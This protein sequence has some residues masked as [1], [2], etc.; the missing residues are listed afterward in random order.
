MSSATKLDAQLYPILTSQSNEPNDLKI[1]LT[2]KLQTVL[3]D[4]EKAQNEISYH[5][6]T[7]TALAAKDELTAHKIAQVLRNLNDIVDKLA[8]IRKEY[9]ALLDAILSFVQS[10]ISTTNDIENYF[11]KAQ[12]ADGDNVSRL[13]KENNQFR[14]SVLEQFRELLRQSEQ[15]IELVRLK[16]P[17]GAKEHDTDRIIA[18]LE[19]LRLMFESKNNVRLVEL[20]KEQNIHRFRDDLESILKSMDELKDQLIETHSRYK[21]APVAAKTNLT[22]FEHFEKTIQV[23]TV[24]VG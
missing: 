20:Q 11:R 15:L 21:D 8:N 7:T 23:I 5:I 17:D 2:R 12:H 4:I 6:Q 14:D 1:F 16:E 24:Y 19:N 10:V 9:K 18:L 22:G 3:N 13:V